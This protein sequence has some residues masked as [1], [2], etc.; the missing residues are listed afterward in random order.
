[1]SAGPATWLR[2]YGVLLASAVFAAAGQVL[3]KL[4]A[5]DRTSLRDFINLQLAGG[6]ALYFLGAVLWIA[7]LSKAPLSVA[8]PFTALTFVLVYLASVF[9]LGERP[10]IGAIAGVIIVLCGLGLIFRSI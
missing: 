3:F 4:G 7:A 2:L 8:Y 6:G 9:L 5:A 1:V 10:P